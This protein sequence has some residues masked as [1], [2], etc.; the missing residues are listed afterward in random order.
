VVVFE[1]VPLL[2]AI[3]RFGLFRD[4]PPAARNTPRLVAA[5]G[6]DFCP[7]QQIWYKTHCD[8]GTRRVPR[9]HLVRH[10]HRYLASIGRIGFCIQCRTMMHDPQGSL[11]A[12]LG[13]ACEEGGYGAED[14][15]IQPTCA[16]KVILLV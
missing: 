4:A 8:I 1:N 9:T 14:T 5:T 3:T 2:E 12:L 15:L 13:D 7:G 11:S 6:P 16:A 10:Q